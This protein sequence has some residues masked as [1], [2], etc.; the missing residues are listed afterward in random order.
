LPGVQG[1]AGTPTSEAKVRHLEAEAAELEE[2]EDGICNG[3]PQAHLVIL[4]HLAQGAT[5]EDIGETVDKLWEN[6][7]NGGYCIY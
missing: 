5:W 1:P 6:L 2:N 4:E 3:I 7:A